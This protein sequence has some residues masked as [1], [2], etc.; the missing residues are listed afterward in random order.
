MN[1]VLAKYKFMKNKLDGK[2]AILE[3]RATM[4]E[5]LFY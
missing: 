1:I 4:D 2:I 3:Y 5:F